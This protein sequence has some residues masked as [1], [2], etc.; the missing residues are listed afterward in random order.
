VRAF[1]GNGVRLWKL[2]RETRVVFT[3]YAIFALLGLVSAGLY[4]W[5][6]TGG[7]GL[8][9]VREYYGQAAPAADPAGGPAI[10]LAP[11]D[12]R[13]LVVAVGYRKLLEASHFHLFTVPVLLLVVSHLFALA[14]LAPAATLAWLLLAW[15]M[16]LVHLAAPWI[17]HYGSARLAPLLS[18]SGAGMLLSIAVLCLVSV[19]R[20]WRPPAGAA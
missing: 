19:V 17:V 10:E 18:V 6:L 2:S 13:P 9:G 1:S 8:E 14:G 12:D 7:R 16:A 3:A 20:M 11:G 5:E 4:G 15:T